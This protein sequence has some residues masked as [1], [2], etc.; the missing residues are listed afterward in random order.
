MP[1]AS[2][3]ALASFSPLLALAFGVAVGFVTQLVATRLRYN[4]DWNDIP[5]GRR[6]AMSATGALAAFVVGL[7]ILDHPDPDA[8]TPFVYRLWLWQTVA[9]WAGATLLDAAARILN[10]MTRSARRD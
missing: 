3:N 10:A 7:W 1:D 6:V 4:G 5:L 2:P 9:A 8:T